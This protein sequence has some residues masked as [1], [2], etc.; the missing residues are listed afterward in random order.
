MTAR[1]DLP[2]IQWRDYGCLN[3]YRKHTHLD[4]AVLGRHPLAEKAFLDLPQ[5]F[6]AFSSSLIVFNEIHRGISEQKALP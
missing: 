4:R 5:L 3:K 2:C 6:H 1:I